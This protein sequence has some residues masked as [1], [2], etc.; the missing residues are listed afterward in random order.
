VSSDRR[1]HFVRHRRI[2]FA[3]S[4]ALTL[5]GALSLALAGLNLGIDFQSGTSLDIT[6]GQ[7]MT[8]EELQPIFAEAGTDPALTIG[9]DNS[10]RV[11]ARFP[12]ALEKDVRDQ[13]LAAFRD[14]YGSDNVSVEETTVDAEMAREFGRNTIIYVGL[15]SLLIMG[16]V[17]ARFEWRFAVSG[18]IAL[19]LDAFMVVTIFSV[20]RLEVNLPFVA[21]VLTVIGYSINDTIVIF[22][23]IRENLRFAKLKTFDD[24]SELVNRSLW[25]T[26]T[27][28]INTGVS[29]LVV[30]IALC[31]F[32]S[33]AIRLFSLAM[34]LG[35]VFGMYSSLFIAG[36]LWAVLKYR[37]LARARNKKPAA[38]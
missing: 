19:F 15:A 16:Y 12:E 10:D 8:M 23:R 4:I 1:I 20:F 13:I 29:V 25:Q 36:Q 18:I 33:E 31:V 21:A 27:R 14:K 17:I 37:S 7:R 24:V 34:I 30:A 3:I 5:I 9:G 22:D 6:T 11:S 38:A 26:L 28:T 35:I 2:F 32:G